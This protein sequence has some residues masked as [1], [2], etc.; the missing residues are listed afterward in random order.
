MSEYDD[1]EFDLSKLNAIEAKG[2]YRYYKPLSQAIA[3][4]EGWAR[5]PEE[6][7]YTGIPE[8]DAVMRGTAPGDTT[9]IQGFTHSGKTLVGVEL[10]LNNP[11]IPL[12]V[13]SPDETRQLLLVKL[14]T[15]S[16]GVSAYD[17]E[18]MIQ[19]DDKMAHQLLLETAEKYAKLAIFEES[20]N[21]TEMDKMLDET[22][23]ALGE[24]PRA[25][26]FD[27]ADLLAGFDD[28]RLAIT[29][30]KGWGKHHGIAG[31]ILHQASRTSGG[32]GRKMAIDSGAYGGEQQATHVIGVRRK[33][34]QHLAA[35]N[36]LEQRLATATNP[37]F[38]DDYHAKI[39]ELRELMILD[40]NTITVSLVKNKRPPGT[41]V[42]DQDFRLDPQTGR[43]YSK[44]TRI[45]PA[46]IQVSKAS[47]HTL[48]SE[49][50]TWEERE[51]VYDD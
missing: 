49:K 4:Y 41:L 23:R 47:L 50:G 2:A 18:R 14:T 31:F 3:E 45:R 20:V 15:A 13:V 48:R 1:E 30:L 17:L 37:K 40:E 39:R 8:L 42:D 43:L 16:R 9:I 34:Y 7:V 28:V 21:L 36:D 24:K 44:N 6:R 27:Y 12:M 38:I 22:T 33:K 5:T 32:D 35:I 10:I 29:A 25:F 46:T 11:D 19:A 51:F 26:I